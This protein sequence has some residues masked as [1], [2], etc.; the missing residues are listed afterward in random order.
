M[1]VPVDMRTA[2]L[3]RP[4]R[5]GG[6]DLDVIESMVKPESKDKVMHGTFTVGDTEILVMLAVNPLANFI[7]GNPTIVMLALGF[8][9]MIGM[10]LIADGFGVH[11]PRGYVYAAMAFSMSVEIL[12]LLER[13]RRKKWPPK[14]TEAPG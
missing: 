12:N 14:K 10:T 3:M 13:K 4:T 1:S 9:I 6:S 8:L 5:H 11:V 2:R 7:N